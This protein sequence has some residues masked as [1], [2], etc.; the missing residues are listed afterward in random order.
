MTAVT[1]AAAGATAY[2]HTKLG[3][4]LFGQHIELGFDSADQIG[5]DRAMQDALMIENADLGDCGV[6]PSATAAFTADAHA[7]GEQP[8]V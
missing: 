7:E 6:E 4:I 5:F 3:Q 8:S 2:T 1:T